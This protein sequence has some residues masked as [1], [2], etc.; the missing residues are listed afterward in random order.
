L[1]AFSSGCAAVVRVR[2]CEPRASVGAFIGLWYGHG[3]IT[4]IAVLI[5]AHCLARQIQQLKGQV[6]QLQAERASLDAKVGL[7]LLPHACP[8]NHG[9][10]VYV[11]A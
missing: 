4:I 1:V 9:H 5:R 11:C 7:C 10:R 6:E 3:H 8:H 2:S